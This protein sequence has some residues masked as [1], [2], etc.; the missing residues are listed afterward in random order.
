MPRGEGGATALKKS[1]AAIALIRSFAPQRVLQSLDRYPAIYGRLTGQKSGLAPVLVVFHVTQHPHSACTTDKC[2]YTGVRKCL[3]VTNR[4]R[5]LRQVFAEIAVRNEKP[6]RDTTERHKPLGIR[7]PQ[8]RGT[9]PDLSL[10]VHEPSYQSRLRSL[11]RLS[12]RARIRR[13]IRPRRIVVLR[14]C[15]FRCRWLRPL[16][17]SVRHTNLSNAE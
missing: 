13:R 2:R 14:R 6:R 1:S 4:R 9:C 17:L 12:N 7:K 15:G 5:I 16:F 8:F 3:V 11:R 10:I